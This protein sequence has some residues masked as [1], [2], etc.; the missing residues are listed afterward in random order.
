MIAA[1]LVLILQ[2]SWPAVSTKATASVVR[3]SDG[4]LGEKEGVCTGVVIAPHVVLTAAHCASTQ[5]ADLLPVSILAKDAVHDLLVLDVPGLDKP[6]LCLA[7][8]DGAVQD[9][10]LALGYGWGYEQLLVR[11]TNVSAF[12]VRETTGVYVDYDAAFLQGMSGGPIVND[13]SEIVGVVLKTSTGDAFGVPASVIRA[14]L[15]RFFR[16]N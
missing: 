14:Q 7:A 10:V 5:F 13:R 6:A 2:T 12:G 4:D 3:L 1:L 11:R 15:G 8:D 9:T 16:A